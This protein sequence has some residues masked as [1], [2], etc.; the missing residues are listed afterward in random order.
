MDFFRNY[1]TDIVVLDIHL[2]DVNGMELMKEMKKIDPGPEIILLT[3]YGNGESTIEALR[4]GAYDYLSKPF[5]LEALKKIIIKAYEKKIL[6]IENRTI[7]DKLDTEEA[8]ETQELVFIGKNSRIKEIISL[9]SDISNTD[10]N[11][12]IQGESGTGKELIARLIHKNSLRNNEL[13]FPINCG[14]IPE[15][16]LESELFGYEK[17]AFTGAVNRKLGLFEVASK[18]TIFLDEIGDL[19]LNFQVKLLRILETGEFNR[20]GGTRIITT[21]ARIISATNK[22]LKTEVEKNL[23]RRDLYYRL[24]VI[25]IPLPP[26]R[27]RSED[28]P[29]LIEYFIEKQSQKINREIRGISK[30]AM[31]LLKNYDWPG[32]VRELQNMIDRII[33]LTPGP[34][35]TPEVIA[36]NL[37]IISNIEESIAKKEMDGYVNLVRKDDLI[38]LQKLEERYIRHIL[39]KTHFN[40]SKSAT[41]L[42]ISE[43]TLYRK[44][45]EYNLKENHRD[46]K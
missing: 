35:I 11:V 21:D 43:R 1:E 12:L 20:I 32:N 9:I 46:K 2:G 27:E 33:I 42:N 22:D 23:F 36:R 7:N 6:K 44:I 14:A 24:N 4:S 39:E 17:G 25:T 30:E 15:N 41:I 13:F 45:K 26:L 34:V 28:I 38:S 5:D 16:L 29:I 8:L 18:G 37:P 40:K 3:G 10:C 31:E 19:P